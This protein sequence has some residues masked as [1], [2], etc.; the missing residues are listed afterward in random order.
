MKLIIALV[1]ALIS[2][3]FGFLLSKLFE[4]LFG[5]V[6]DLKLSPRIF[7]AVAGIFA[8]GF[9]FYYSVSPR[10]RDVLKAWSDAS[11]TERQCFFDA[12]IDRP[13]GADAETSAHAYITDAN[14]PISWTPTNCVL[15]VV[16]Y[17]N[18]NPLNKVPN[19]NPGEATIQDITK[20]PS[21]TIE[22]KIFQHGFVTASDSV[23]IEVK[24]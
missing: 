9:I 21:G 17:Q 1:G 11:P 6:R 20:G 14:T 12:Q 8:F 5:K 10:F 18:T 7:Y 22:L 23:W 19:L 24:P 13:K 15:D 2:A 16:A 4:Y 3:L